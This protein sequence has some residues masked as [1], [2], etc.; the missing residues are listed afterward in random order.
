MCRYGREYRDRLKGTWGV[1]DVEDMCAAAE[2]LVQQVS[3]L[4]V[5]ILRMMTIVP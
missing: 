5:H 4:A 2:H 1:V 3:H